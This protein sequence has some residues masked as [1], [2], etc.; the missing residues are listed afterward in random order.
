MSNMIKRIMLSELFAIP[1][2]WLVLQCTSSF[3]L[4]H[5]GKTPATTDAVQHSSEA[6]AL[7]GFQCTQ[8]LN[9]DLLLRSSKN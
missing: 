4:V 8:F 1:L 2:L 3:I 7:C 9:G 6:H 5:R